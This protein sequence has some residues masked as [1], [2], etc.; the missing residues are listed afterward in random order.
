L[1]I[2]LALWGV[3]HHVS[4]RSPSGTAAAAGAAVPV[5]VA[6]LY[7]DYRHSRFYWEVVST[8]QIA[9]VTALS[10]FTFS[11]GPYYTMLLLNLLLVCIGVLQIIFKPYACRAL[12]LT[13]LLSV[14]TL[15]LTSFLALTILELG[16]GPHAVYREVAG[17]LG[18][19]FN[20]CFVVWCVYQVMSHGAGALASMWASLS[21]APPFIWSRAKRAAQ[22]SSDSDRPRKDTAAVDPAGDTEGCSA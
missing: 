16:S 18:L 17:V 21:S 2:F 7:S 19:V 3:R 20:A 4:T 12:H 5:P 13:G 10:V 6:F 9:L 8:V 15:Y 1:G 22:M 14:A 11:L